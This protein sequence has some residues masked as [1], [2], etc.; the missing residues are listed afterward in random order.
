MSRNAAPSAKRPRLADV[1][2]AAGVSAMTVSRALREP[3]RL[4]PHTL[5][6]IRA[7]IDELG[8]LPNGSARS[9]ASRRSRIV[10][11]VVPTLSFSVYAGTLQGLSDGLRAAG[12]ELML[13]DSGYDMHKERSLV[14]AFISRGVDALVL[15]GVEHDAGIRG[16]VTAH[17][18]P[19][20]E[21]WDLARD[22]LDICI[23]FSN[24]SAGRAVGAL[25]ASLGRRRLAFIGSVGEHRSRKRRDGFRRGALEAGL[26]P[27]VDAMVDDGMVIDQ[28]RDAA[29]RLLRQAEPI[30]AVFCANDLLA[31]GFLQVAREAGRRVPQEVAVVGFG[32]FDIASIATPAL[33]TVRVPGYRMGVVAAES[34]LARASGGGSST[35]AR[36]IDLGYELV[37]RDTV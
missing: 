15:T 14:E 34:L 21:I 7:K 26:A 30:D 3:H 32:D 33:T 2:A 20:A 1:A 11:A 25:L 16:L 24:R 19:V 18:V 31:C 22:P 6:R 12:F 36:T 9:L 29:R 4:D 8:Y 17:G 28:A 10:A 13:G 27:P 5:E 35:P 23:G 37:R